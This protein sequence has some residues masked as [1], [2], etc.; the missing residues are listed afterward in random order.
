M[1]RNV[2]YWISSISFLSTYWNSGAIRLISEKKN[3]WVNTYIEYFQDII[4][5]DDCS[6]SQ[7][8]KQ[9]QKGEKRTVK[10]YSLST[11]FLH[12]RRYLSQNRI[13][14]LTWLVPWGAEKSRNIGLM[15]LVENDKTNIHRF[16]RKRVDDLNWDQGIR[17]PSSIFD[18]LGA[19]P[20]QDQS[21]FCHQLLLGTTFPNHDRGV[22]D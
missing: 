19:P 8:N 13:W 5:A 4:V 6:E 16:T 12:R 1:R 18:A 22:H 9:G 20:F 15:R 3:T 21:F 2:M 14:S 10:R 11:A 7:D 17:Y